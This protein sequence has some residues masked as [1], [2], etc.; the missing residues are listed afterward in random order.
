[1]AQGRIKWRQ[2]DFISLGKAVANFNK[3]IREIKNEENKLYLPDEMEYS[4]LKSNIVTRAE[5]NRTI[6][7]L[8][9]FQ[10]EGA[11]DLY[12]T[13]SGEKLT[14][15]E[16]KELQKQIRIAS[17][18]LK[19]SK[20]ILEQPFSSG[21]SKAQMGSV[22]YRKI[23]ANLR[24][25]QTLEK[26]SGRDF[27]LM[28]ER[29]KKF[30]SYDYT[31]IKATIYMK[32]F[33]KALKESGAENFEKYQILEKKLNRIKNPINF[34]NLIQKSNV[35]SDLF[36][37]YK[38]GEGLTYGSFATDEERFEYGLEELEII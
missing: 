3:K 33:M 31:M 6:N 12:I 34:F 25:L 7:S 17:N 15:W 35:F 21:Y 1:M 2:G 38:R 20:E 16:R 26:K 19:R 22:E 30:G 32:N 11:E 36:L 37:Y 4:Q 8:K 29:I 18:E 23:L 24:S 14:K 10:K 5:L 27:I 13:E 9:R 28:K